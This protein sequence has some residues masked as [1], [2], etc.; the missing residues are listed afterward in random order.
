[1][2]TERSKR[3][4]IRSF[5]ARWTLPTYFLL[6]YAFTWAFAIPLMFLWRVGQPLEW[7]F[8]F[9]LPLPYGP[10]I[11]A[12]AMTYV[13]EGKAGL[14]RLVGKLF[15]WRVS[16]KWYAFIALTPLMISVFAVGLSSFRETALN[17]FDPSGWLFILPMLLIALPFGPLP[18]EL[19]W[20]GF[21]LPR[22][23][24]R[25]GVLESGLILGVV[26]TFWHTPMFWIGTAMSPSLGLSP[27]VVLL[28]LAFITAESVLIAVVWEKTKG[29]VLIATLFHLT[30]NVSAGY[31][32]S[33]T[34]DLS[35]AQELEIETLSTA[36]VW[37][38]ALACVFLLPKNARKPKVETN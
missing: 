11:A 7:W 9:F 36:L 6:S 30:F 27:G 8:V 12:L 24:Q 18:E 25:F 29:S 14:K 4:A 38:L 10:S 3:E 35:P 13:L 37:A 22:L 1:M 17:G 2:T 16:W 31:L 21:A 34:P 28:Y 33:M 15:L 19:G 26:W 5:A 32:L 20:R 23:R